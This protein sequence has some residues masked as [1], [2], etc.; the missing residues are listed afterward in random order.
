MPVVAK[1][2]VH[3]LGIKY[4]ILDGICL[5]SATASSIQIPSTI[6]Y[7]FTPLLYKILN[8]NNL[9]K[10]QTQHNGIGVLIDSPLSH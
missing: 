2:V 3:D 4:L 1:N 5:D 10:L 6:K 7:P 8:N 9:E